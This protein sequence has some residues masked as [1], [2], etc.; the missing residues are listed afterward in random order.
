MLLYRILVSVFAVVVLTRALARQG[1]AALRERLGRGGPKDG[2]ARIWLHA[3]SNGELSSVRPVIRAL[4]EARPDLSLIVTCNS[5]SGVALAREMGLDARLAPVDLAWVVRRFVRDWS[6]AA[7]VA[8]ESELWP[9]RLFAVPGPVIVLGGRISA[10]SARNWAR[11]PDLAARLL[12]RVD[13][14][15]PQDAASRERFLSLGLPDAAAG[16]VTELKSLYAPPADLTSDQAFADAYPRETTWLAASTHKGEEEI[17]IAAHLE[18]KAREPDLRLI[19]ALRHPHRAAE[20]AAL[21]REAGLDYALRS[22]GDAPREVLLADTLGEMAHWY[23]QAGRVFIGGTLT[24]RGGH[25]PFEPAH[26]G[27]AI[28]HGPDVANFARPFARLLSEDAAIEVETA[29]D[30]AE[31]LAHLSDPASQ[32]LAGD[33]ARAALGA[34]TDL[35]DLMALVLPLLPD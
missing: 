14:L 29:S 35:A 11:L 6:V 12:G 21:L 26:F 8:V 9:N 16:P 20:V 32:A 31:G 24:D 23:S 5:E 7:H 30:L 2:K 17:V 15:I 27:A 1:R 25:T 4:A 34:E 3:A 19:L 10:K 33:R 28:L 18:A 22:R 13:L